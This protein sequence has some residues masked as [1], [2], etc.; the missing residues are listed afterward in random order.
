M[1]REPGRRSPHHSESCNTPRWMATQELGWDER[2]ERLYHVFQALDLQDAWSLIESN[3]VP[4]VDIDTSGSRNFY[5]VE[6]QPES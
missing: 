1:G 6:V 4:P 2:P 5:K 3:A